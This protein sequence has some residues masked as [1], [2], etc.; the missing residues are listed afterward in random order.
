VDFE[1]RTGPTPD[2]RVVDGQW[3]RLDFIFRIAAG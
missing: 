1:P 3:R 2:G